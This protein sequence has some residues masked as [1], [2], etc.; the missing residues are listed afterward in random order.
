MT[1]SDTETREILVRNRQVFGGYLRAVVQ[2]NEDDTRHLERCMSGINIFLIK[3]EQ[4]KQV[5][6]DLDRRWD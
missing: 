1:F 2:N 4:F 3:I 5:V 6:T